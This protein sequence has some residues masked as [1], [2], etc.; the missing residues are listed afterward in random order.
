MTEQCSNNMVNHI[1]HAPD[2]SEAS[3]EV[4]GGILPVGQSHSHKRSRPANDLQE[5]IC[6]QP[7]P[8]EAS[9]PT[10]SQAAERVTRV[11]NVTTPQT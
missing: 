11:Q 4:S 2:G 8:E 3:K 7:A 5:A 9:Q 6:H 1:P 10:T